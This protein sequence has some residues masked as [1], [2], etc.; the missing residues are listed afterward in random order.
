[1]ERHYYADHLHKCLDDQNQ[2]MGL[3]EFQ[4]CE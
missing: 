2:Q 3:D 1:M 4:Q